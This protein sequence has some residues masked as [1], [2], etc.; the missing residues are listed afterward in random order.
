M[1]K[2][3]LILSSAVLLTAASAASAQANGFKIFFAVQTFSGLPLA[4]HL[5]HDQSGIASHFD[6]RILMLV[7]QEKP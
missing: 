3:A 5:I 7:R 4:A 1:K 2:S 6:D